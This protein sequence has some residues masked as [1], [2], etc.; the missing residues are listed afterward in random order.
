MNIYHHLNLKIE[1]YFIDNFISK[2]RKYILQLIGASNL[3]EIRETFKDIIPLIDYCDYEE[4]VL[5]SGKTLS[6]FDFGSKFA[7]EPKRASV[8][9]DFNLLRKTLF[10]Y[11]M[12]CSSVDKS[13]L[14]RE[15]NHS[16]SDRKPTGFETLCIEIEHHF[17]SED[18]EKLYFLEQQ[19]ENFF[20]SSWSFNSKEP[21]VFK[22]IKS[23]EAFQE[24]VSGLNEAFS[25]SCKLVSKEVPAN[26]SFSV[27][28]NGF[29]RFLEKFLTRI[30]KSLIKL[31]GSGYESHNLEEIKKLINLKL[32]FNFDTHKAK[33]LSIEFKP[34]FQKYFSIKGRNSREGEFFKKE[35]LVLNG[36]AFDHKTVS[37]CLSKILE[38]DDNL[39]L[40]ALACYFLENIT[41]KEAG[42]KVGL[43]GMFEDSITRTETKDEFY[44][45]LVKE[46]GF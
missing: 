30:K 22:L 2:S 46:L 45:K 1:K 24:L 35:I 42:D 27:S 44:S 40:R 43:Q 36:K 9:K 32:I 34:T 37:K 41:R 20:F 28:L 8:E 5:E 39:K 38:E 7:I 12:Y 10:F 11:L 18:I 25:D 4:L 6:R 16:L 21:G 19:L 15:I 23:L 31:W 17:T 33:S 29:S 13:S 14:I 3:E 26:E